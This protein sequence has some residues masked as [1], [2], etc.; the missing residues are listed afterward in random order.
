MSDK[1][2][3]GGG[4][5]PSLPSETSSVRS[6]P[7][8]DNGT[9][10]SRM[11]VFMEM[12]M[13]SQAKAD[14]R[15]AEDRARSDARAEEARS[16]MRSFMEAMMMNTR[17][18]E[19][20]QRRTESIER[21]ATVPVDDD[22]FAQ[23]MSGSEDLQRRFWKDSAQHTAD[24]EEYEERLQRSGE[25][26]KKTKEAREKEQ[27]RSSSI[28]QVDVAN[29]H[30]V[31]NHIDDELFNAEAPGSA[32]TKY[33][34]VGERV[35]TKLADNVTIFRSIEPYPTAKYLKKVTLH[36]FKD[37]TDDVR[38]YKNRS[39]ESVRLSEVISKEV[40]TQIAQFLT[41][42]YHKMRRG[43]APRMI[44]VADVQE[45]IDNGWLLCALSR[46]LVPRDNNHFF[47]ILK[48]AI[49]QHSSSNSEET[50]R[51]RLKVNATSLEEVQTRF[52]AY[53][54][55]F[56]EYYGLMYDLCA[57]DKSCNLDEVIPVLYHSGTTKTLYNLYRD[58]CPSPTLFKQLIEFDSKLS[59]FT[60]SGKGS[61][62]KNT[63]DVYTLINAVNAALNMLVSQIKTADKAITTVVSTMQSHVST[64]NRNASPSDAKMRSALY[65][66]QKK[67][68]F[69]GK[70]SKEGLHTLR[71]ATNELLAEVN[72][73]KLE[74]DLGVDG[75][76]AA[77]SEGTP[78]KSS[79]LP[80]FNM[81]YHG[82]CKNGAA[83][84]FSHSRD[85]CEAHAKRVILS[86]A[87]HYG[88]L[89]LF[90]ELKGR[91]PFLGVELLTPS[92]KVLQR[93][94]GRP[95]DRALYNPSTS[96]PTSLH[97]MTNGDESMLSLE[98]VTRNM[99]GGDVSLED[100]FD[101]Y[102]HDDS[103]GDANSN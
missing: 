101:M 65:D 27:R 19:T 41:E 40:Q 60:G 18:A 97:A 66:N 26:I 57:G 89:N 63:N 54:V 71:Q 6:S 88:P 75:M 44:T 94:S 25:E 85:F 96:K 64:D 24:T 17:V 90:Q 45:R 98:H 8:S 3:T 80:C 47:N 1:A 5:G 16:E 78:A 53:H 67:R 95:S 9:G 68:T 79:N 46:I 10:L 76:I 62:V 35:A 12:L 34:T 32:F 56:M 48:K 2:L 31:N 59:V 100:S 82:E 51:T 7:Q 61:T 86:A 13:E 99:M 38:E 22:L 74:D 39:K 92:T 21:I 50:I 29:F 87:K 14:A 30:E 49:E 37:W 36:A 84:S 103:K 93:S 52:Y 77:M 70:W 4:G 28:F 81:I 43:V 42:N 91:A 69:S 58:N 23:T 33:N 73:D 83:C 102:A 11:E 20:P 55:Y 15:A 72:G